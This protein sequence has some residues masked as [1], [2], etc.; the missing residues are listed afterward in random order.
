[1]CSTLDRFLGFCGPMPESGKLALLSVVAAAFIAMAL[2]ARGCRGAR[3]HS[4]LAGRA[5]EAAHQ[6]LDLV[7]R[8]SEPPLVGAAQHQ[9]HAVGAAAIPGIR[10]D[11]DVGVA[12]L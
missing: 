4:F 5:A 11:I 9:A 3:P 7:A 10:A 8:D 12:G 1:M 6:P 2:A